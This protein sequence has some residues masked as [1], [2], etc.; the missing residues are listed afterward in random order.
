MSPTLLLVFGLTAVVGAIVLLFIGVGVLNSG[1]SGVGRSLEVL[2]AFSSAPASMTDEFDPGFK[3]RVLDPTNAWF[4]RLGRRL[5]PGD[6]QARMRAKL[7]AA[8]NPS[9]WSVEKIT[10][11]KASGF[12]AGLAGAM[13]LVL[14]AGFSTRVSVV[15]AVVLSL[16][17]YY[18]V[19]LWLYQK[20]SDRAGSMRKDIADSIDLLTISV[21][22]G[23]GFDA[24]LAHVAKNTEGPLADEFARMLQEMQIGMGRSQALRALGERSQPAELRSFTTA[25]IQADAFGIPVGKVLRVQSSELRLKR[26]QSAEEKAQKVPVKI[27]FP[28]IFFILPTLF[29]IVMGPGVISLMSSFGEAGL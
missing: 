2:E 24:A 18:G 17:G 25:M 12:V 3:T 19:D 28:L 8:G 22:A 15:V 4:G 5:T 29:L 6:H 20:A 10:Q 27:L 13:A 21:E 11:L 23:L 16:A 9:G 26:R 7:D 1:K 14:V